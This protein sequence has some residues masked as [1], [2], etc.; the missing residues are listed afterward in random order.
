MVD[1]VRAK[2]RGLRVSALCLGV[3][4][5]CA[6]L[7]PPP[8]PAPDGGVPPKPGAPSQIE[9]DII[10]Y[11][12]EARQRN[13]LAPLQTSGQLI[14]AS[15][16]Q[17]VQMVEHSMFSHTV[18]RGRYPEL[19]DR[20]EAAR[21]PYLLAAENIGWNVPTPEAV[22]AGWMNSPAHRTNILNAQFTDV[23]AAMARNQ[24]GEPYWVQ[25]FGKPR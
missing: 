6:V 17:A 19:D 22:V 7:A 5:G 18:S 1:S 16:L 8:A 20:L 12:N 2:R 21:Y 25:V 4:A 11:T 15:R 3:A 14:V 13:G 9:A 24:R 23:G 10:R